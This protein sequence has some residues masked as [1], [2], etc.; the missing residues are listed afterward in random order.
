FGPLTADLIG[1]SVDVDIRD[2]ALE[3]YYN[4]ELRVRYDVATGEELPLDDIG[5]PAR[6]AGAAAEG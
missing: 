4:R 6:V 3:V 5:V 1:M 2:S